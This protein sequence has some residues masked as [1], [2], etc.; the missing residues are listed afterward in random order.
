MD[1]YGQKGLTYLTSTKSSKKFKL[2]NKRFQRNHKTLNRPEE[3]KMYLNENSKRDTYSVMRIKDSIS[4]IV[5]NS[6]TEVNI[7]I[8]QVLHIS[9]KKLKQ[10]IVKPNYL[11][12]I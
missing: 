7:W 11:S 1:N 9:L 10:N 5:T 12:G 4:P 6:V 2:C 8:L 3:G